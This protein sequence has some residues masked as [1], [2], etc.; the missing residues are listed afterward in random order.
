MN[1][2]D[3]EFVKGFIRMCDDGF[4]QGWHERNGGNLSYILEEEEVRELVKTFEE[5]DIP[6]DVVYLDIDYMD[7]FRV[8]TFK[9]PNFLSLNLPIFNL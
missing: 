8:M 4:N 7:G 1:I 6:L 3:L 2:L 9:T 5:K